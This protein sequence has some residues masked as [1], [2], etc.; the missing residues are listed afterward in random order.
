[1][2]LICIENTRDRKNGAVLVQGG[3]SKGVRSLELNTLQ[4][5][6]IV[7]LPTGEYQVLSRQIRNSEQTFEY[8]NVDVA[9]GD[10][11]TVAQ[12]TP[13]L[14]W[15]SLEVADQ[16]NV[17][18]GER[19]TASG[20]VVEAV[21]K[22]ADFNQFLYDNAGKKIKVEYGPAFLAVN[23]DGEKPRK[24]RVATITWAE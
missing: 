12:L 17:A 13:G 19:K 6:D 14:F 7:T 11:Q 8:I 21:Q 16:N 2:K 23:Y 20:E 4:S 5:G 24:A 9:R 15:R 1:M 10:K 22:Y 18:T 3:F